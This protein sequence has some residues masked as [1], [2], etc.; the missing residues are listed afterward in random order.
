MRLPQVPQRRSFRFF[1]HLALFGI[2]LVVSTLPALASSHTSTSRRGKGALTANPASLSFGNVQVGSSQT[3]TSTLTNTGSASL[4]I[5]ND[6]ASGTG[7][8]LSGITLPLTLT[9][10][11]SYTFSVTFSPASSGSV[12][13][14]AS[15]G[16]RNWRN[17]LA[18]PLTGTGTSTGQLTVSPAALNFG[19]VN[20]G[21]TSSLGGTLTAS[22]ASVT[23]SS[24]TSSNSQFVLSGVSFPLT[25]ASGQSAGFTVAF[26][27]QSSGSLT[28][29]L[30]FATNSSGS[31]VQTLS[32]TGVAPQHSVSLNWDPST[33]VV[34]GY[35]VYRG[36]VSGGP[37]TKINSAV[38][39]ATTYM[40][41]S[42]LGG[43]TYYY[44]TTAVDSSGSESSYSNQVQATIPTP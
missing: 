29:T 17:S 37:Y 11:Q 22:G 25:L 36:A 35:N 2:L 9:V 41:G 38:D 24:A 30:T 8:S 6:K 13:G 18:I 16:S 1:S 43:S 19:N 12:S 21:T 20:E 26:T 23:V 33:S 40:D 15:M 32:G 14:V 42:V 39:P 44:V 31:A 34:V 5:Y 7:Y 3:L 4:T 27:P 28:G 10:G